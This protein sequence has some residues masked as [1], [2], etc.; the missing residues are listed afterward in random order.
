MRSEKI[1]P[2]RMELFLARLLS[3]GTCV[4]SVVIGVGLAL[5]LLNERAALPCAT[6]LVTAGIGLF[7]LLPILRVVL[8]FTI[9]LKDRDYQFAVAAAVVFLI[10]FAG[11][12][13]GIVSKY[14]RTP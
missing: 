9:Y 3:V 14:W 8:M 2:V 7:I 11:C 12:A 10:I 1:K 13:I 6:Q 4:A 5:S